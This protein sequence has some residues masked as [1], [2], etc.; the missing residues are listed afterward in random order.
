MD[1]GNKSLTDL[2]FSILVSVWAGLS[3][4]LYEVTHGGHKNGQTIG[5]LVMLAE[6]LTAGLMGLVTY[7]AAIHFEFDTAIAMLCA[8]VAGWYNGRAM[9]FFA[10]NFLDRILN[11]K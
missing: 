2:F 1:G 3:H 10:S 11:S 9:R 7:Y 5:L 6:V 4:Y 8:V